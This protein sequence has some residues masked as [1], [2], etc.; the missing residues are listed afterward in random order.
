MISFLDLKKLNYQYD[1]EIQLAMR[2]V[3]HSGQYI[4]SNEVQAF[5][6]EFAEYCGV[7]HCIGVACGLDALALIIRGYRFG[8]GDE[9]IVP[10]NTYIATILAVSANGATPA[11]VEPDLFSYNIDPSKIERK[12]T[13]RT[14]AILAVHLYGLCADMTHIRAIAKKYDL[15]V[16]EDAAQAQGAKNKGKRVGSLGNAAGFSFYPTKNLGALGDGGAITT[17]DDDLAECLRT[18]RDYGSHKKNEH[19]LK[20]VNSR[21]DELQ[22]AVL[23]VKLRHLDSDNE[24]R[25]KIANYYRTNINNENIVLPQIPGRD[26]ESHVWHLFVIRTQKRDYL[27]QYLLENKIQTMIHYPIPPHEQQAYQEWNQDS[28]PLTEKIHREVLSLPISPVL[29]H[30]DASKIVEVLNKY[31]PV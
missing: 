29:S 7:R 10:A 4:L 6:A 9:I 24:K 17:N 8:S 14:K 25:R 21:L 30:E 13:S 26:E 11:L 31:H 15:K 22:A 20:G 19:I 28:Y 27:Q 18:L 12:I 23:R 1:K 16:I 2:R 5:E 3:L